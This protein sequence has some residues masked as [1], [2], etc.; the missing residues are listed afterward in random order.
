MLLKMVHG[1]QPNKRVMQRKRR[2]M[3][4][5]SESTRAES[6]G[7]LLGTALALPSP[8]AASMSAAV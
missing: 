6:P 7:M 1:E 5:R 8:P 4:K 2:C 3:Q